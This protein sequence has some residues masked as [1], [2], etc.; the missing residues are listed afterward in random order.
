M[1]RVHNFSAGPGAIPE[2]VLAQAREDMMNWHGNGL[3]VMEMS[4]RG[5]AFTE[6]A[7]AAEADARDLLEIPSNYKVLFLQGGASLQFTMLAQN[8]LHKSADYIVTGTWGQK[9]VE[10][11]HLVADARVIFDGKSTKYNTTPELGTLSYSLAADYVHVT[12]NE[13][14]QGVEFFDYVDSGTDVFCDM[15][16]TIASRPIDIGKFALVY[17]GAQKN[18]GPAGLTMVILREDLLDKIPNGLAPMLDYRIQA[19]NG[20]MY[21]TPPT[22]SIYI[23]G[24]VLRHWLNFGGLEAVERMNKE[25]SD[26]LYSAIDGS[27]GFYKGHATAHARS[28][29]NV[30]FVLP[31]DDLTDAFLAE[32]K[33]N[34]MLELKGHRSVGGCRASIYNAVPLASVKALTDFMKEFAR[35][36]G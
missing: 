20:S 12:M 23:T 19:E 21:N 27:G 17:A 31:S 11:A 33:A 1:T 2:P 3:S 29:M 34:Q 35:Q 4:H 30:P 8:F 22:W 28:R 16:S 10:A 26:L 24:L 14:I 32:A 9:A 5:K 7:V 15:S 25:K 36:N 18:L 13:T 6:I